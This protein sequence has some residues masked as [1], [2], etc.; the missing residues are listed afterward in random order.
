MTLT[1]IVA[2]MRRHVLAVAMV[3][4]VAGGLAVH[5]KTAKPLYI[6][7][8][9]VAFTAP[10]SQPYPFQIGEDLLVMSELSA[11]AMMNPVTQRK[12]RAAGGTAPYDV[13]LVNLNN[14][15][16]PNYSNPYVT[17]T[18]TSRDPAAAQRTYTIVMQALKNNLVT[19]QAAEG[20]A[21]KNQIQAAVFGATGGPI[22]QPGYPKRVFAGLAVLTLLA[23]FLI[24]R[25]LDRYPVKLR[26]LLP[27]RR[28]MGRRAVRPEWPVHPPS[29]SG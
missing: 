29:A 16:Y 27:P 10:D 20:A 15:D 5:F 1:E 25:L 28:W 6:D 22:P 21:P 8:A 23:A 3:L 9:T 13:S 2:L 26:G 11:R 14:E 24:S 17:V 7:S 12:V 18:A 19:R 4:L